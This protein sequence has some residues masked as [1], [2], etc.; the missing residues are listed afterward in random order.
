MNIILMLVTLI[1]IRQIFAHLIHE[2]RLLMILMRSRMRIIL[3]HII[4]HSELLT[5]GVIHAIIFHVILDLIV[6]HLLL[7]RH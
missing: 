2:L 5:L 1:A 6:E 4:H 7:L 3:L